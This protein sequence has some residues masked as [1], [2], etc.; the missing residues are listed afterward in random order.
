MSR[1]TSSVYLILRG[2]TITQALL[3]WHYQVGRSGLDYRP[4]LSGLVR[5]WPDRRTKESQRI[6]G[7]GS[8]Y[9]LS[10]ACPA[11]SNWCM[12]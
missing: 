9:Q 8:D 12:H 3:C 10:P 5:H 11:G 1:I 2:S 6:A 4:K 7:H